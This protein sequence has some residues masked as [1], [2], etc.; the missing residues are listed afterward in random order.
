VQHELMSNLVLISTVLN[1][2]L[3]FIFNKHPW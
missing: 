2:S 3:L 1:S